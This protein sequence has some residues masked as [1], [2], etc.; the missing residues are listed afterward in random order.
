MIDSKVMKYIPKKLHAHIT[1]CDRF[2]NFAG[3]GY[4]YSVLFDYA[5][6][7]KEGETSIMADGVEGL[8]WACKEVLNGERG[9]IYG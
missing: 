6:D 2:E 7:D 8:K 1:A 9:T 5:P 3:S 4:T